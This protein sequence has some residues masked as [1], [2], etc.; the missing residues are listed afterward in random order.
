M[1]ERRKFERFNTN[2]PTR[3]GI[4]GIEG[5]EEKLDSETKNLSAGGILFKFEKPLPVGSPV[6]IEIVL[7]FEELRATA[8]PVGALIINVSGRVLRSGPDGI[9]IRFNEDYDINPCLDFMKEEKNF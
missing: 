5:Q 2:V 1:E 7:H 8:D 9:A 3:I 6:K 4:P